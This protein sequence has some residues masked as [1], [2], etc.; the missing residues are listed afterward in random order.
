VSNVRSEPQVGMCYV[1]FRVSHRW[2]SCEVVVLGAKKDRLI[3]ARAVDV[4]EWLFA[5]R[6]SK[7]RKPETWTVKHKE[8]W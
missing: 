2:D 1:F 4:C 6:G 3:V 7:R 5:P 8:L